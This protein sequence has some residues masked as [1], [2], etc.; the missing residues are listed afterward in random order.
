MENGSSQGNDKRRNSHSITPQFNLTEALAIAMRV[1]GVRIDR[2]QYLRKEFRK[3]YPEK[4]IEL[5]IRETPANAGIEKWS[6]NKIAN[7]AIEY[8]TNKVAALSVAASI[9]GGIAIPVSV[10][11]DTTQYFVAVLRIMQ[12]LAYLYGFPEMSFREEDLDDKTMNQV[13][14]FLGV[15]FGVQGANTT[16]INVANSMAASVSKRL[17]NKALTKGMVYPMVKKAASTIGIKI[18]KQIFADTVGNAIPVVGSVISGGIT[19][20]SF[21]PRARKLQQCFSRTELS[22]TKFHKYEHKDNLR[23]EDYIDVDFVDID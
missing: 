5:A 3:Y 18:T 7:T 19:Y 6:V 22:N 2:E 4:T 12:K 15:M 10:A 13:M 20:V 21:K 1:P 8:E 16:V 9:P 23:N 11:V 14:L 17:A